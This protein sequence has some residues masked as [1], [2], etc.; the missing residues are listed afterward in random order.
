MIA[1]LA[2]FLGLAASRAPSAAEPPPRFYIHELPAE[3]AA[4]QAARPPRRVGRD[5][6]RPV[7]NASWGGGHVFDERLY[8]MH[9]EVVVITPTQRSTSHL[10]R[11]A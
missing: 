3:L 4:A 9:A 11:V 2:C 5:A 10:Q 8:N 1:P 6:Q 7:T